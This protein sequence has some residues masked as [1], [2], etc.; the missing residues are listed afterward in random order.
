VATLGRWMDEIQYFARD[1]GS[2]TL[3]RA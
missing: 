1:C 2:S 3:S